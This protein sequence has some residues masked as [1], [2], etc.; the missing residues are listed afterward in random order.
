[1]I[2]ILFIVLAF[3]VLTLMLLPFQLIGIAC[4]LRLQRSIPHWYHRV[5]C[6]L[7]GVRISEVG[8]RSRTNRQ[9][10]HPDHCGCEMYE[11]GEVDGSPVVTCCEAPEV[12]EAA[13]AALDPIAL[14]VGGGVMRDDDLASSI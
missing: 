9:S 4:D 13:E 5:L 7:I 10:L 14:L 1:M 6:A 2:R 11:A 12:F 8:Q 3:A